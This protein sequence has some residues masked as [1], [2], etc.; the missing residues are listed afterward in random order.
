M[1]SDAIGRWRAVRDH[2]IV[3]NTH[4]SLGIRRGHV[5]RW[6]ET[7]EP[8]TFIGHCK[9]LDDD[10]ESFAFLFEDGTFAHASRVYW[11]F[12]DP[13]HGDFHLHAEP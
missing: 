6:A 3:E 10:T 11:A 5:A 2:Y 1:P 7:G 9:N 8:C 12:I 4:E 13:Q